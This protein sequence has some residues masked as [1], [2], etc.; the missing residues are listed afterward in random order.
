[1]LSKASIKTN[2]IL[3]CSFEKG[4]DFSPA[5]GIEFFIHEV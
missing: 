3:S 1:V 5:S 2:A 4:V